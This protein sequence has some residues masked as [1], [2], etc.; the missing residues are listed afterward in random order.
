[1]GGRPPR[2]PLALQPGADRVDRDHQ[3]EGQDRRRQ[4]VVDGPHAA[5]RDRRR[6]EPDQDQGG[7]GQRGTS[8]HGSTH[9]S[10]G[11]SLPTTK[12][13]TASI[14]EITSAATI[15]P[16]KPPT[17][18][19]LLRPAVMA[20]RTPLM[21]REN[22][23]SV[24]SVIGAESSSRNGPS[25]RFTRAKISD[26]PSTDSSPPWI[27]TESSNAAAI[28]IA[29]AIT[30]HQMTSRPTMSTP[31]RRRRHH[32]WPAGARHADASPGTRT[33]S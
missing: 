28:P 21:T 31:C 1:H 19:L 22:S 9:D 2:P 12:P 6:G 8:G 20:S 24:I 26:T 3:D 25:N 29:A 17:S 30:A 18:R 11:I 33:I 5:C 15:T 16:R 10:E 32:S 4:E 13:S 27:V 14:T 7:S 23:P